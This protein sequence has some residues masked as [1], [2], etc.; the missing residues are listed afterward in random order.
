MVCEQAL[1]TVHWFQLCLKEGVQFSG[2]V[3][4]EP[5]HHLMVSFDQQ[6]VEVIPYFN[7]I[8]GFPCIVIDR[9]KD[10]IHLTFSIV[11]NVEQGR[12][13]YHRQ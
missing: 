9:F 1:E 2:N 6:A 5:V 4:Q 3:Q 10:L 12:D 11:Q 13:F 7:E 8:N